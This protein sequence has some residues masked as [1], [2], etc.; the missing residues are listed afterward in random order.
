MRNPAIFNRRRF[1][2]TTCLLIVVWAMAT[3]RAE[4]SA[5]KVHVYFGNLHS[6]T[7]Y[8]DGAGTPEKAFLYARDVAKLDF[9]AVT[10]HNHLL[11]GSTA[12]LPQREALYGGPG[13]DALIPVAQRLTSDGKFVALYGQEFST[14]SKGNHVNVFDVPN[15]IDTAS[16]DFAG[17]LKWMH[18]HPDSTGKMGV[19]Q[20]NH[21]ALG[22][23]G[24]NAIGRLEFGR[25]DFTDDAGWV[26]E[27]GAA[28]S[29]VEVLNGEP[30]LKTPSSRAP[31]VMELFYQIFLQLGFHVAPSGDQDNHH[32]TW[33]TATEARTG[34]IAPALTTKDLLEAMRARHVYATEDKNLRVIARVNGHLCGDIL[35]AP[36]KAATIE[37]Q[38]EDADE[39]K[40][41]Y[42][43]EVFEGKIG[44][45][46][47][48]VV[49]TQEFH[50][51]TPAGAIT[52]VR[53]DQ[54]KQ[55]VFLRV[56]QKGTVTDRVWTA[57]VWLQTVT[58]PSTPV[59]GK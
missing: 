48:T 58:P 44:G 57:P 21:P 6:H 5:G 33:G 20:L 40:A 1:P 18:A 45:P 7:S 29:L 59:P 4:E 47:A 25:D 19:L 15:V 14:M 34:I 56:T 50:G 16:G 43:V 31:Q 11:G 52:G 49:R 32:V 55:Y 35:T 46:I 9:L 39:P 2:K 38:I 26:R 28:A 42:T 41:D 51:N 30:P 36:E 23:P 53:L 17:L 3:L 24:K 13:K 22:R 37:I 10:E 8:S 12:A 27:M 54:D